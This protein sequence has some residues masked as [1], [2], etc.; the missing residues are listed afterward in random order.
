MLDASD[1]L[2]VLHMT[3]QESDVGDHANVVAKACAACDC[4]SV[5]LF[6]C[7]DEKDSIV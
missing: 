7:E 1:D 3:A 4:P 5:K 2:D 6:S